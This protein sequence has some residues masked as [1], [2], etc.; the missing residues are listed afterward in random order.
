LLPEYIYPTL[1]QRQKLNKIYV[2]TRKIANI[3]K[4]AGNTAKSSKFQLKTLL[5]TF[6]QKMTIDL[7]LYHEYFCSKLN[8]I[9]K[10]VN[11]D[12]G[13]KFGAWVPFHTAI[14]QS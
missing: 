8:A 1:K 5:S 9:F 10:V 2:K 7:K 14:L 6:L 4:M 3:L 13:S 12:F 11:T